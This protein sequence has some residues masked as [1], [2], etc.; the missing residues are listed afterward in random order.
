MGHTVWDGHGC[1]HR[2]VFYGPGLEA[3]HWGSGRGCCLSEWMF[4]KETL[5]NQ[6]GVDGREAD[7]EHREGEGERWGMHLGLV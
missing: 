3:V 6:V 1:G 7:E 4:G 2:L 5:I